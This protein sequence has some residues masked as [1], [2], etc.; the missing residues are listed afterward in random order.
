MNISGAVIPQN[1]NCM[2]RYSVFIVFLFLLKVSHSVTAQSASGSP[3]TLYG[4]GDRVNKGF[5]K[6]TG[7][8]G[9]GIGLR[10][11]YSLNNINPASYT[12]IN[13]PFSQLAQ[14]G[15][16]VLTGEQQEAGESTTITELSFSGIAFWFRA[17]KEWAI[18]FGLVPYSKV[19]YNLSVEQTFSGLSGDNTITYEGAGGLNQ[20]YIGSG[21][22]LFKNFSIGAHASYIF[23]AL[24]ENQQITASQYVNNIDIGKNL[25]LNTLNLDL[26][27]QYTIPIH[28]SALT[29]GAVY[30][31]KN[32]MSATYTVDI[33]EDS[34]TTEGAKEDVDGYVLPSSVG[35]G[36]SWQHKNSW[37]IMT[38]AS[39]EQWDKSEFAEG[40]SLRN[41]QRF[42][43]GFS[44]LPD[45][46]SSSYFR[47]IGLDLG[48]F[49]ENTYLII[50]G[51]GI[52][53][54]GFSMGLNF[55]VSKTI[56]GLSFNHSY[57]GPEAKDTLVKE[58]YN[59]I[60]LNISLLD[61]WFKRPQYD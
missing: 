49:Y 22:E 36:I 16:S 2:N 19:G 4:I 61:I 33:T 3:Y 30:D 23:G 60:T 28:K 32:K 5:G 35:I 11:G 25:F 24:K 13:E 34:E 14:F 21:Y 53:K 48:M 55:P 57:R 43:A 7:L 52:N 47:R 18:S 59:Q 54:N 6:S 38:D 44:L 20:V 29:L 40:Y 26:G 37:L 15:L 45:M 41:N 58:N 17:N 42:S 1:I 39:F 46:N 50:N 31:Y 56:F 8:G 12:A 10:D 27:L 51:I 9:A